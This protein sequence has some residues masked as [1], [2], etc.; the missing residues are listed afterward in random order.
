M[1]APRA[2][3]I[4]IGPRISLNTMISETTMGST[5]ID[6]PISVLPM[7]ERKPKLAHPLRSLVNYLAASLMFGVTFSHNLLDM[8]NDR[9]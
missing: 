6:N 1:L 8:F 5:M 3:P 9:L 4:P 7:I 2:T